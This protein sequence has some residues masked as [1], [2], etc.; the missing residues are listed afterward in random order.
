MLKSVGHRDKVLEK[1]NRASLRCGTTSRTQTYVYLA[2]PNEEGR[3]KIKYL[4]TY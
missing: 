4:E 1:I 2:S 3:D